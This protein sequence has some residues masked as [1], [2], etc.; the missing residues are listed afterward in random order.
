MTPTPVPICPK[1]GYDQSG[2]IA[3]WQT[4]CPM[5]GTCTECGEQLRWAEVFAIQQEWGSEVA[6][7]AEHA[8]S[9]L[10]MLKRTPG[11]LL[12]LIFPHRYF[13]DMN[14]RREIRPFRLALWILLASV[15]VH[16]IVSAIG[17]AANKAEGYPYYRH[18]SQH[19][20]VEIRVDEISAAISFP[21]GLLPFEGYEWYEYMLPTWAILG[22]PI[23]W[24]ILLGFVLLVR[25]EE[26][27]DYRGDLRL[28]ARMSLL[29]VLPAMMHIQVVRLGFGFHAAT[30]MTR[31]TDWVPIAFIISIFAMLF[32]QQL[33]WT[34]AVRNY[35]HIR[36]SFF[37]N[38]GGC[39]GSIIFGVVFMI[40]ILR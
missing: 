39:F 1:C 7:Y 27:K 25:H 9:A 17:Y 36:R 3:T 38:I 29:S 12:R 8:H 5:T 4:Q 28:L 6:W 10:G 35:W 31:M 21:F 30:G 15:L 22:A 13:R 20:F 11:T 26:E 37:I 16:L 19:S 40:W 24:I 34:H 2:E 32:W 23:F 33:L 18:R 14:H